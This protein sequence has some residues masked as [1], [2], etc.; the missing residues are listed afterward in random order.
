R[1]VSYG[2]P[3][4]GYPCHSP[5]GNGGEASG[6]GRARRF[7]S[8]SGDLVSGVG[9]LAAGNGSE[10][11]TGVCSSGAKSDLSGGR[12][13]ENSARNSAGRWGVGELL[14]NCRNEIWQSGRADVLEEGAVFAWARQTAVPSISP[15]MP[16]CLVLPPAFHRSHRLGPG[17]DRNVHPRRLPGKEY[18]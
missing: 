7:C 13:E 11:E 16:V 6:A 14:I 3:M 2:I 1:V 9:F 5:L 17:R 12:G 18:C 10:T 8:A 4:S 15:S